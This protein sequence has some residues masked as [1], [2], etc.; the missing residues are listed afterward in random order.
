MKTEVREK[1]S[2]WKML[3]EIGN[4]DKAKRP[5][6]LVAELAL[7]RVLLFGWIIVGIG[8]WLSFFSHPNW[9]SWLVFYIALVVLIGLYMRWYWCTRKRLD[10]IT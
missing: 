5:I 6:K 7:F 10:E 1:K 8:W 3:D 2:I 9:H 4:I